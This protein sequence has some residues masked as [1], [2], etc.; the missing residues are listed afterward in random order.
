MQASYYENVF[1][2]KEC[3]LNYLTLN[4]SKKIIRSSVNVSEH[5][6][7]VVLLSIHFNTDPSPKMYMIEK[8]CNSFIN[9][10]GNSLLLSTQAWLKVPTLSENRILFPGKVQCHF[11]PLPSPTTILYSLSFNHPLEIQIETC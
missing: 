8:N 10:L 9:S 5:M 4:C 2:H 6:I 7:T 11:Y 3:M 1:T